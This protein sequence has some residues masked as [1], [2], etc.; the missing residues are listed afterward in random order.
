MHGSLNVPHPRATCVPAATI[1][2]VSRGSSPLRMLFVP[3]LAAHGVL[4]AVHGDVRWCLLPLLG[5]AALLPRE[6]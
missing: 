2:V 6:G 4:G 5:F 1:I 3:L